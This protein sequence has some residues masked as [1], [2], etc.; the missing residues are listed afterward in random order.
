V[1]SVAWVADHGWRLLPQYRFDAARGLW[2][3]R[4]GPIEPPLR[5]NQLSYDDSGQLRFPRHDDRA[6]EGAYADA[7]AAAD[8]L[9]H[10]TPAN[11]AVEGDIAAELGTDFEHL[12]WFELPVECLS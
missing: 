11:G 7:F 1:Q 10:A 4:D 2:K 5:L 6:S 3:H 12:R 9:L 8:M